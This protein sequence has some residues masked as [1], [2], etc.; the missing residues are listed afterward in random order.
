MSDTTHP[1]RSTTIISS[2]SP[3]TA[4]TSTATSSSPTLMPSATTLVR[5]LSPPTAWRTQQAA[6]G[7]PPPAV[8]V[9]VWL[10]VVWLRG[11]WLRVWLCVMAAGHKWSLPALWKRLREEGL[12]VAAIQAQIDDLIIKTMISIEPVVRSRRTP[13]H[14]LL[15]CY[16]ARHHIVVGCGLCGNACVRVCVCACVVVAVVVPR[17]PLL[18]TC[19]FPTTTASSCS[20]ST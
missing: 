16:V 12:D 4:S 15:P 3:T 6:V 5:V 11:V 14:A 17:S 18:P 8:C 19:S 2:T 7:S 1:Q 10:R 13:M 9:C 20:G